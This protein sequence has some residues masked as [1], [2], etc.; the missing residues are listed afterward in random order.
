LRRAGRQER[1]DD[2]P[3]TVGE[4]LFCHPTELTAFIAINRGAVK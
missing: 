3:Q 4:D 1:L 2:R